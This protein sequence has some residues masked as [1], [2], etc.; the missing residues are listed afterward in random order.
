[1]SCSI[2]LVIIV[3]FQLTLSLIIEMSNKLYQTLLLIFL[4]FDFPHNQRLI[5]FF[6]N[7]RPLFF[8]V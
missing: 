2:E 4:F 7:E 3:S 1:M 8:F 5:F 6:I